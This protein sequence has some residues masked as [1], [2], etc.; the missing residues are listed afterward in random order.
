LRPP[1]AL[2]PQIR[3]IRR[4]LKGSTSSSERLGFGRAHSRAAFGQQGAI[5]LGPERE[6]SVMYCLEPGNRRRLD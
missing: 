4:S 5:A 3:T 6:T 2:G 1:A